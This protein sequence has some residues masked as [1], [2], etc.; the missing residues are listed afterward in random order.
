MLE[1]MH[2]EHFINL[3]QPVKHLK[4]AFGSN[5]LIRQEDGTWKLI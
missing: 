4:A 3:I 1:D 5:N 2:Y